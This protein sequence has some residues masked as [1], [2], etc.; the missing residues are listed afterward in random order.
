MD[1]VRFVSSIMQNKVITVVTGNSSKF[2]LISA[3]LAEKG[4]P[5]KQHAVPVDELQSLD[6]VEVITDKVQKAFAAVGGPV[7]V[8]DSGIYFLQYTHFPGIFSKYVYQAIGFDGLFRLVASGDRAEFRCFVA[9]R[10]ADMT[11]PHIFTGTY[12]GT[13]TNQ[14]SRDEDHSEMPYAAMFQPDG[15]EKPLAYM[16]REE[17]KNDHRNQALNQFAVWYREQHMQM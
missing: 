2:R 15:S 8:D 5:T 17:R 7:L 11:L 14:F 12:A 10:D 1:F 13:I 4:I 16:T 3:V 9:Y 6:P